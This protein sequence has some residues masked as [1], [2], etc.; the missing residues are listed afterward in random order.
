MNLVP[1]SGLYRREAWQ[2]AFAVAGLL[3]V[4]EDGEA[5]GLVPFL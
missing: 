4:A 2:I 3:Q 1:I 5:A